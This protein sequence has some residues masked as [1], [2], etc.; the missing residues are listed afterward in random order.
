VLGAFDREVGRE[1]G[2]EDGGFLGAA[3]A[4]VRVLIFSVVVVAALP[5]VEVGRGREVGLPLLVEIV[6]PAA[7]GKVEAFFVFELFWRICNQER[8]SKFTVPRGFKDSGRRLVVAVADQVQPFVATA[9]DRQ[10]VRAKIGRAITALVEALKG[11][12]RQPRVRRWRSATISLR[13]MFP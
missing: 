13:V 6:P 4:D 5:A 11:G 12:G 7:G 3:V 10:V 1:V 8:L 9:H 2:V